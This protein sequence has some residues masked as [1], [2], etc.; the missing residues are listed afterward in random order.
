MSHSR[1]PIV[2][3]VQARMGST[4]LP[5][6]VMADIGGEPMLSRVVERA[7]GAQTLDALVVATTKMT[8]ILEVRPEDVTL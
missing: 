1:S 2:A 8:R 6:K 3:I 5:G 4:R 7:R